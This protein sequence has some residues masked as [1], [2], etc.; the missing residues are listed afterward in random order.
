MYRRLS[1]VSVPFVS[2]RVLGRRISRVLWWATFGTMSFDVQEF[3]NNPRLATLAALKK[4]ELLSVANYYKVEVSSTIR[5]AELRKV[6]S[7]YL[8]DE[9]IVSDEE[10]ELAT[11]IELKKLELRER[12]RERESLMRIKELE[13]RERELSIQLKAK[14]LEVARTVA[15]E[16]SRR[17][18][19]DMSKNVRFV[20]PFQDTEV[21]KYFLHFEKI[22]SSLE[23]P[24]EVWTLLLQSALLGK[25]REV[26]SALS[27]DQSS[28]YDVV[29]TAILK[30]Y[31]LVPEAY[32]Q[33]FR[34]C[35]KEESQT[36]VEFARTKENLFDRWCTATEVNTEFNKLRQ[37]M[38]LEE[39]KSCLPSDIKTHLDE[40]RAEDLHQAAI[41][42][43]DYALTH[44]ASF[45]RI[46]SL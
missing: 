3:A 35:R 22:A 23:W 18:K 40:R 8:V 46:Q 20:P 14:E 29:K 27:V 26:Y 24:K 25:A 38:L 16:T 21:D 31:E 4:S 34:G 36:Y 28:D 7:Q 37:L 43:D 5:K 32:R 41:W 42:A 1:V 19:F 17:E 6:I 13:I 39:F 12:E 15:S 9:E 33:Q 2:I 30:A 10:Y 11:D 44:K 45:K